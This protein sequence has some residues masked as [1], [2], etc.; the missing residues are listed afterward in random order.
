MLFLVLHQNLKRHI[1]TGTI[2]RCGSYGGQR[3]AV[4][5]LTYSLINFRNLSFGVKKLLSAR[6]KKILSFLGRQVDYSSKSDC[7]E[8]LIEI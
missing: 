2:Q 5:Y 7:N 1:L 3:L 8:Y 6:N 4:F